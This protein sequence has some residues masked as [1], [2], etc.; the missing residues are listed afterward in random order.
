MRRAVGPGGRRQSVFLAATAAV[1]V[2]CTGT[3][4]HAEPSPPDDGLAIAVVPASSDAD[5]QRLVDEGLDVIGASETQAEILV[6]GEQDRRILSGLGRSVDIEPVHDELAAMAAT[7]QRERDR[8]ARLADDP[9]LRSS[10]PTGRVSYRGLAET[11]REMRELER[12]YPDM[13]KVFTLPNTSLLGHP[14]LGMEIAADV[15]TYAGEPVYL[16][17]GVHHAREWPTLEFTMEFTWDA[18]LSYGKDPRFTRLLDTSRMLVVPVVNPDGYAVSRARIHEMKRKNCRMAPGE[19]PTWE[20]CTAEDSASL[21]VDLNRN[22]GPFWGGPGSSSSVTASNHHGTAPYSEPEIANMAALANSHQVMVAVNNHTPDARLL[23]APS[24]PLEPAPAEEKVYDELAQ[25]LGAALGWPAGPWPEIYY[26]ASGTAEENALY[27]N[28]TFG[29]T[30]ELMPGF[31]GLERFHPPYEYVDDQYRGTGFYEGSSAREALLLGWEAAAD[32]ALH[33]VVTGSAPAGIELTIGRTV[34]VR[35]SP[36]DTGDGA[37]TIP[38]EHLI[39]TT[40]RVPASGTFEWHVLPSP[41]QS[42]TE[43]SLIDESWTVSCR[44]PAGKAHQSVEV[45]I[46]RGDVAHVDLSGCPSGPKRP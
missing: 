34:T 12:R 43:S 6:H 3:A 5:R 32:D 45:T 14:V 46:A 20:Q 13:V 41:R 36:V 19:K 10:L 33:S 8:A 4:V 23:R 25:K 30:P 28:G 35:S 21:G 29:F 24:S 44:N 18:L 39:E 16:I 15:D 1:V 11:Q 2:L 22:Y 40:M 31:S 27:V 9:A 26:E 17:S 37:T 7:R 42:Q 38:T